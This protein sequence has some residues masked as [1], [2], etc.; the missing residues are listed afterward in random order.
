[1][2]GGPGGA[3]AR[4]PAG[5]LVLTGPGASSDR[6]L[7]LE[8]E[9]AGAVRR[10]RELERLVY[11]RAH[12]R[13]DARHDRVGAGAE[14]EQDLGAERLDDVH[15]RVERV[16]LRVVAGRD[17]QVLRPDAQRDLLAPV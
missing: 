10:E 14:V 1:M 17:V 15:E 3:R 5:T 8:V 2:R 13:L 11:L 7:G 9:E 6:Q 16:L 4:S 12:G